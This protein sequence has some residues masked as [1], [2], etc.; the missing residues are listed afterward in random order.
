[1]IVVGLEQYRRQASFEEQLPEAVGMPGE[2]MSDERGSDAWIDADEQKAD[3]G[4]DAILQAKRLEVWTRVSYLFS[5]KPAGMA[6][7]SAVT[8]DVSFSTSTVV[9]R[10]VARFLG[11]SLF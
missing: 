5:L 7:V 3:T 11:G 8:S 9:V 2:V 6:T 10:N 4:L 1:M